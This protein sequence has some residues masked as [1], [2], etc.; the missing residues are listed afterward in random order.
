MTKK[1]LGSF[2]GFLFLISSFMPDSFFPIL[3][4]LTFYL[5]IFWAA[6]KKRMKL[7]TYTQTTFKIFL[8]KMI[9]DFFIILPV[10]VIP[11]LFIN[12][13]Y[14]VCFITALGITFVWEIF[15]FFSNRKKDLQNNSN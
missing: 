10:C 7:L 2:L 3:C 13:P 6:L 14:Q 4:L 8:G 9:C 12:T 5:L 15:L 1:I 11:F